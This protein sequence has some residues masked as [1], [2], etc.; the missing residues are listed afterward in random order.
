MV[1]VS[2]VLPSCSSVNPPF[3]IAPEELLSVDAVPSEEPSD[4]LLP[5]VDVP[6]DAAL[7]SVDV[8]PSAVAVPSAAVPLEE[9]AALP[10]A[11]ALPSE[12]AAALPLPA[13][14]AAEP[15]AALFRVESPRIAKLSTDS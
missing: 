10:S 3:T 6:S 9:A 15:F 5:S 2:S 1:L 13:V 11:D 14:L 7:P 12:E 4:V 8:L